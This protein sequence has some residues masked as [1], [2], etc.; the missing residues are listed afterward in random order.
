MRFVLLRITPQLIADGKPRH[1][2][3]C[4]VA[5]GLSQL[6]SGGVHV[7][8]SWVEFKGSPGVAMPTPLRFWAY[9]Y[10]ACPAAALPI[11]YPFPIPDG[12]V[13]T[14]FGEAARIAMP[15]TG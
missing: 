15:T 2:H 5:L 12:V 3:L 11:E 8:P 1:C 13:L 6:V 10:D 7:T 4:P 9:R 14:A